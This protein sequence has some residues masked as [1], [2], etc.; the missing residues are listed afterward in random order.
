MKI[1]LLNLI[2]NTA[3]IFTLAFSTTIRADSM[4]MPSPMPIGQ[5]AAASAQ[6]NV[7][8][9]GESKQS[10]SQRFGQP[11]SMSH[12][13]GEPAISSWVYDLYTVY[14]ENQHVIHSV[15]V[16]SQ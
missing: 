16:R 7:P 5:H 14:F 9:R 4:A 15:M 8:Q 10:V 1:R 2:R 6:L 3:L 11:K 13:V 12:S